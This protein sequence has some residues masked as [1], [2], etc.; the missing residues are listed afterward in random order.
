MIDVGGSL[1]LLAAII[2]PSA[3][4]GW[5]ALK[6]YAAAHHDFLCWQDGRGPKRPK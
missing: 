1:V 2:F 5:R 4:F 3:V 6:R